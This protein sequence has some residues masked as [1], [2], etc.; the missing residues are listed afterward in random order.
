MKTSDGQ[1]TRAWRDRSRTLALLALTVGMQ[2]GCGR[3]FFREWANQDVSEAV[4]EKSRDPRWRLDMFSVE[5]PALSRFADP[6]DPDRPPAP[7]DDHATEALSPVPQWPD[8]RLIVPAEGTGYLDM[9]DGWQ[10]DHPVQSKLVVKVKA[11]AA[12]PA[13]ATAPV[14]PAPPDPGLPSPFMGAPPAGTDGA[15]PGVSAIPGT[16][17]G[18]LS[19]IPLPKP[20]STPEGALKKARDLG[21]VLTAFQETGL[22]LPVPTPAPNNTPPSETPPTDIKPPPI[23]MD[24]QP[25][26]PNDLSKPIMPPPNQT[27]G[28]YQ[29]NEAAA[30]ELAGILVPGAIDFDEAEAV[31]LP[32]NA[33]PYILTME[34]A[35]TLA[36]I[37]SRVYQFQLEQ[38][39][40]GSLALTLQRFAFTPQFYAGLTPNTTVAGGGIPSPNPVNQFLYQTRATGAPI[41]ALNMGTVAGVG[42]VFSTGGRIVAGFA[43]QVVFNFIGKNSFQPK[44]QSYLPISILQPFLR[45]GGRAVTLEALTQ[46]ERSLLYT[47]RAF[48]KFRQEF[49]V[50]TLI[51]GNVVQFGTNVLSVGFS[52]VQ[53]T[54]PNIGFIN[55]VEDV[56]LLENAKRNVAAL[57]QILKVYMEL[58]KG[59]PSGISQL[60]VDQIDQ[61]LQNA[62]FQF[63]QT[64]QQY[65]YDS[66]QYR[67][68]I[69]LPP[70]VPIVPDRGLT[71]KFRQVFADI[72]DW[73]ANPRRDL[74]ELLVFAKRLPQ[75][76]DIVVDGRSV[77]GVY[78]DGKNNEDDLEDLMNAVERTA[79]EH[80]L[81]LMNQ[82]ATLYDNW[83]QIK[84]TANALQGVLNVGITNQ[85]LT[86]PTTNNPF[87]FVDQAKQFSL[88]INAELPL[89]RLAERNNFR[90]ALIGYQ[91]QRRA[92]Q[93]SE[94]S[95]KTNIRQ[96]VRLV[97]TSYLTYE[98]ARRN[99]VLAVRL[100]DQAF[101]LIVAPPAAG[102]PSPAAL[103]TTNLVNFQ[104]SLLQVE[105][106]LVSTWYTFQIN[107]L[108]LYRDMGTLPF[109]EWEAFHE[110]FPAEPLERLSGGAVVNEGPPGVGAPRAEAE[111]AAVGR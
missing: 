22:P 15:K 91:R 57:E 67:Q 78:K 23:G 50:Q 19:H 8:N 2:G 51:G 96:D 5:P 25:N 93:N 76:E 100:K 29:A 85:F 39:Y 61:S 21:V 110:L 16:D 92:L 35:F 24:P 103:Q 83:R 55:V 107:R 75:L 31:G 79:M 98:I 38:V 81:D 18:A 6:Y 32:R 3:E 105:N 17:V 54:D 88:V 37:N 12:A 13:P 14:S 60:Q 99:L 43:N 27:P 108:Q 94:D 64:R 46:A 69:G 87:G 44:V 111:P 10:R 58:V 90:S 30:S 101:E 72:D 28:E 74:N 45:G 73:Q 1:P 109:D 52:G 63:I 71:R 65:R 49:L 80:R 95:I 34:Q 59:E 36:L 84:F 86:P 56:Q 102:A 41:S 42:K 97:Q 66:D 20:R 33:T 104:Q 106:Q 11:P 26:D 70:D 7:P 40:I 53:S 82:R 89:V 9:L 77:L 68:Q 4:F 48:A 47:V 62:K